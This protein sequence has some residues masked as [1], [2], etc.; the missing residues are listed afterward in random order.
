MLPKLGGLT[1]AMYAAGRFTDTSGAKA[2]FAVPNAV[3]REK[4][5]QKLP[6]VEA[7]LAAHFGRPVPLELVVEGEQG[8]T[9]SSAHA[10]ALPHRQLPPARPRSVTGR[11]PRNHRCPL[12]RSTRSATR[13]S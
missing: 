11:H 3:H 6:E 9:K 12:T 1:K 2:T 4:S 13:R 8:S 10:P 7:A 5:L